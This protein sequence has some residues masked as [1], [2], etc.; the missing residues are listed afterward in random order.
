MDGRRGGWMD[1]RRGE[2]I[3]EK[4]EEYKPWG[5]MALSSVRM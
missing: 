4:K 3:Y 2:W 5:K 1:G